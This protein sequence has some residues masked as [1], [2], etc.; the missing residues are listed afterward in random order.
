MGH[1]ISIGASYDTLIPRIVFLS[2][3]TLYGYVRNWLQLFLKVVSGFLDKEK[4]LLEIHR[5]SVIDGD[6]HLIRLMPYTFVAQY[7]SSV[8]HSNSK[9]RRYLD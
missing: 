8:R 1:I 6:R 7:P 2:V 5:E 9:S 3:L 4:E